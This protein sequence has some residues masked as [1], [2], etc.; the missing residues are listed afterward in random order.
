M[1]VLHNFLKSTF[2]ERMQLGFLSWLF[3]MMFLGGATWVPVLFPQEWAFVMLAL[4]TVGYATI[5]AVFDR[6]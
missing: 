5:G 1:E 2:A 6:A 3:M 4:F